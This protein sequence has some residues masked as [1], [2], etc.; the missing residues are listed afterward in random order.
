MISLLA[1][2]SLSG[3]CSNFLSFLG[4]GTVES[5]SAIFSSIVAILRELQ[6]FLCFGVRFE[7]FSGTF[8]GLILLLTGLI[9]LLVHGREIFDSGF[10]S[11]GSL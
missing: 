11:L 9:F 10:L 6:S 8:T 7:V 2:F 3:G 5:I 1:L 4:P